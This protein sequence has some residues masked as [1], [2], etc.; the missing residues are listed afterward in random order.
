MRAAQRLLAGVV[1]CAFVLASCASKPV[2]D[3]KPSLAGKRVE[4]ASAVRAWH[5]GEQEAGVKSDS[6]AASIGDAESQVPKEVGKENA[7]RPAASVATGWK[8]V[9]PFVR[10]DAAKHEVEFDAEVPAYAY[11][12]KDG[13]VY[14]EVLVCTRDTREHE[15]LLVTGAK[16]SDVHAA[17]LMAGLVPGAPGGWEWKEKELFPIAP[18]GE[19]VEVV[20]VLER[21][22][23]RAEE[24]LGRWVKNVATGAL[25][26]SRPDEGF[27]FAGSGFVTRGGGERY[28]A[29]GAG[30]L[31][32]LATFGTETIAWRRV[33]SPES[34]VDEPVWAV[35]R[36]V[37]PEAGTK[38]KVVVRR[39][40]VADNAK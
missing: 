31:V 16:A 6:A 40:R 7:N 15:A 35:D 28:A 21:G 17:L 29:D 39:A 1:S 32:G 12:G 8:E 25:L 13:V 38:V 11:V 33:F 30:T 34:S 10:V 24:P 26:E 3:D 2:R 27:V 37:Q 5:E 23:A 4:D 9:F 18:R 36:S 22:G 19:F 20:L 14:L